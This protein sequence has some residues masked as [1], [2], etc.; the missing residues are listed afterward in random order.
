MPTIVHGEGPQDADIALVGEAPGKTEVRKE[1]PFVGKSGKFLN[2]LLSSVGIPRSDIYIT[3]VVKQKT[4]NNNT[5][6]WK[7]QNPEAYGMYVEKLK[8]EL[9]QLDPN[10]V[11]P[12]GK[13]ALKAL[14][15]KSKITNWRGSI[16]ESTLIEG[17][18]L[19]PIIH[20]SAAQRYYLWRYYI[21]MDLKRVRSQAESPELP[22]LPFE[23]ITSPSFERCIHYLD[24]C[25]EKD[26]HAFDIEVSGNAVSCIS[27]AI[28]GE[29]TA[30]SIPFM[31]GTDRGLR[32]Y[33][34][35]DQEVQVWQRIAKLL[36]NND[37][38]S[39]A[40]NATFDTTFLNKCYGIV[41]TRI[42]DT[43]VAQAIL[44]PD[45]EK[46]LDFVTSIYTRI[47]YYK[48]DG[49][50]A[51]A[52]GE[53]YWR[54]NAKD[55]V[56]LT[57]A[58]PTMK[59]HLKERELWETYRRQ[60]QL[61]E[62][63]CF[64]TRV[65]I[66]A[67]EQGLNEWSDELDGKYQELCDQ[68]EEM[69]GE[70]GRLNPNSPKQ[71]K[72]YFYEFRGEKPYMHNGRPTTREKAL[73]QLAGTKGYEEASIIIEARGVR[74]LK[75]TYADI[76]LH[77]D[78]RMRGSINVVGTRFGRFS[79]S[80]DIQGKGGNMQN[81]PY[82]FR[83]YLLPDPGYVGYEV[84]LGQAENRV[85]AYL[86]PDHNMIEA[87]ENDQDIHSKTAS[88]IF[89]LSYE[90][91]LERHELW[92]EA[93]DSGN[94]EAQRKYAVP[95]GNG[96][97]SPRYWGKRSNHAF[98]Y[99]MSKRKASRLLE[100]EPSEA[101]VLRN[102]YLSAYPGVKKFWERVQDK[103]YQDRELRNLLGRKY[104]FLDRLNNS[105][106]KDAYSF[107]PQSTVVDHLNIT[108]VREVYEDQTTYEDLILLNQVHDSIWFE[109]PMDLTWKEHA[110]LLMKLCNRM[111]EPLSWRGREFSIP[112]EVEIAANNFKEK[113]EIGEV[114]GESISWFA[115]QLEHHHERLTH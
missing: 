101:E 86:G 33:F 37:I 4:P 30:I 34:T 105:T 29:D 58:W 5:K 25:A 79:S 100:I 98:N 41:P 46:G 16:I 99:G 85:V 26:H 59:E 60:Q 80:Q 13:H 82:G 84:D 23:L 53:E 88:Y 109:I 96:K 83:E 1:R 77:E 11:V 68:L 9:Q 73:K 8:E 24:R 36:E 110:K 50:H 14:A 43:M 39:I 69:T 54:Y 72:E 48:D 108:A 93:K 52:T 81:L 70:F 62:P 12:V 104:K 20:P 106:F 78:G 31:E 61:I 87:F 64:M 17:Q 21:K 10:V 113:Y 95:I 91:V 27:F 63:A 92:E 22:D 112:A 75:G 51:K 45:F 89:D 19:V 56:V 74:K 40:H 49:K 35:I 57:K 55:S 114:T 3:N 115:D 90:E 97:R 28:E 111:E 107:I 42:H 102:R 76:D 71:V 65:G 66:D 94:M 6:K 103:L 47:P 7:K 18:K 67:N 32:E 2:R 44:W 15:D 38:I